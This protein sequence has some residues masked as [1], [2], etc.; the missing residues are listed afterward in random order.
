MSLRRSLF[1]K[2]ALTFAGLVTAALLAS[3]GLGLYFSY[4]DARELVDELQREKARS[5]AL[6]IEQFARLLEGQLRG[7]LLVEQAGIVQTA[8]ERHLELIRLLRQAPAIVDVAWIDREDREQVRASRITRDEIGSGRDASGHPGLA[9][10]RTGSLYVSPV[11]FRHDSE[12]FATLAVTAVDNGRRATVADNRTVLLADVNLKLIWEV[13]ADIRIGKTGYAYVVDAAGHLIS[14]PDI[15]LVLRKT[16]L[17][18]LKQVKAE[19]AGHPAARQAG[20]MQSTTISNHSG[21]GRERWTL[22]AGA[23]IPALDWHVLVE[24]PMMEVF[25]PLLGTALRTGIV[26]LAGIALAALAALAL[27][28]RMS[29]PIRALQESA[30]RI[31]EGR[32]QERVL[33]ATQDELQ[34]LGEQF[35]RMADRLKASYD[36][37]E[38]KVEARTREL[39]AA[40]EAKSR[41]LAAASHDLRQPAHALGLFVA[42]LRG[43]RTRTDRERL[44]TR[45][46]SSSR[47][48]SELLESLFDISKLDAGRVVPRCGVFSIQQIFDR[49]EQHYAPLAQSRELRF[50]IRPS[51]ERV[52]TDPLLLEQILMNLTANAMRYTKE[53]GVL[54]AARRRPG[55]V[56]IEIWDTGIGIAPAD[57]N[58]IFDEFYQV[59]GGVA[60]DQSKGLGLG[61]AIV[62]RLTDLL[63]LG[64]DVS[65]NVGRGSV[66]AVEVPGAAARS[67]AGSLDI[68]RHDTPQAPAHEVSLAHLTVLVVDD[69]FDTREA[70]AGLLVQWGC[71]AIVAAGGAQAR[72]ALASAPTGPNVIVCDF[73]LAHGELGT[74][75][76]KLVRQQVGAL[77]PALLVSAD[78]QEAARAIEGLAAAHVLSKPLEA[79]KLRALLHH[80]VAE[81]RDDQPVAAVPSA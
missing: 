47:A 51:H 70:V 36:D 57:R 46:E 24:Q 22:T 7:A 1:R 74:D 64:L 59:H 29:A 80:V 60:T 12:P 27:A 43:A 4:R 72:N 28:R 58:R 10:A 14:H 34:D 37:L 11:T 71:K 33:L 55:C 76:V 19:L 8:E 41:F 67:G 15:G 81:A 48:V 63:G 79:A 38:G 62:R 56:R 32:L 25:A 65:S 52:E 39:A 75:V 77:L 61:L 69:D 35:N 49:L 66:F 73:R 21:D 44:L 31:G 17:S 3:G 5:A 50:R 2:Y 54:I 18:E 40:N 30:T 16:D 13:V 9:V 68:A 78:A 45:I 53:G 23:H 20:A 26:L 42:Q 6:R